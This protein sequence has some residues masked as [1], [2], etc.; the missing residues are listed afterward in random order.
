MRHLEIIATFNRLALLVLSLF[1]AS[2]AR[3]ATSTSFTNPI[4]IP[5][6]DDV[7]V[8]STAD[9]NNDGK[10]DLVYVDG[11]LSD[12]SRAIHVLLGN[13]NGTF[14]H[15]QDF[16]LPSGACCAMAIADVTNDGVLDLI[17]AGSNQFQVNVWV[18]IGNGDGSFQ[19]PLLTTFQPNNI[20]GY[21][22]L[23]YPI[24]VGD[25]NGDG[26]ADL[27]LTDISNGT[28]YAL[29]GNNSGQFTY[30]GSIQTYQTGPTYLV[31]L[32]GDGILDLIATDPLGA[33]FLVYLGKGDGTFPSFTRYS[34]G[35]AAGPFLLADVNQDG[36]PDILF[37]YYPNQLGYFP[38]NS[39][40]TFGAWVALGNAPSPNQLVSAADM[41][42]DGIPDLTFVTASGVA[43]ALGQTGPAYGPAQTTVTGGSTSPYSTL[44]VT[45]AVADFNGDGHPDFAMA[46]E[47]GIAIFLGNGNGTFASVEFYDM[48][49]EVGSAAVADFS[50]HGF[51]DIA[52]SLPAPLPRLLLGN[53]TGTFTLG[54][55]PNSSYASGGAAVT[56]LPADFNGDGKPDLNIGPAPIYESFSGTDSVAINA[57]NGSFETP[58]SVPNSTPIMADFNQDGRTDIIDVVGMQIVVS[59]GQANGTFETVNTVLRLPGGGFNVGD[60]NGDG[61]PD[62][63]LSYPDHF[64]VWLGNGDGTFTYSNSFVVPNLF[65]DFMAAVTDLDGD[66]KADIVFLPNPNVASPLGPLTILYGNGDG[67]FQ[68]PVFFATSHRFSWVT[69][70]DVNADGMPDLVLTD[71]A[72]IAVMLNLGNRTFGAETDYIAGRS[73]SVPVSVVDVNGDGLPDIVVGNSGG[74]TVTVLLNQANASSPSGAAVTGSLT[75]NPNPS[76]YLN[77]FTATVSLS[78]QSASSPVPT[79]TASFSVDGV[80]VAQ[81]PVNNGSSSLTEA[82]EALIPGQ[83]TVTAEYNGDANY[84][85]Q[86]FAAIQTIQPPVYATQTVLTVTP[87]SALA[88][89]TVRLTASVSGTPMPPGGV[90]TFYD[91]TNSIGSVSLNSQDI[92]YLDTSLLGAGT[93]ALTAEFQGFTQTAYSS[94]DTPYT[95]AIFSPSSSGSVTLTV[96]AY[97]TV[98]TLSSS[99]SSP[100]AGSVVTLTANV[101]SSE[102]TPFGG[103]SFYD[104]NSLL[105]TLALAADGA[106][107]FSTASLSTGSHTITA[108]F[109][110][111]GPF[112]TST[113]AA[114]AINVSFAPADMISTIV[115]LS[116]QID[117]ASGVST[118]SAEVSAAAGIPAGSVIFLDNGSILATAEINASGRASQQVGVLPSG[119]HSI[120]ASFA[121]DAKY[122]PGVSPA[123]YAQ[124]PQ[125]GPGFVLGLSAVGSRVTP[126]T[127]IT[128]E[129]DGT[130][131]FVQQVELT[132]TSDLP[133]GYLCNFSPATLAGHGTSILT[134]RSEQAN[135]PVLTKGTLLA[136][137][138]VGLVWLA[139]QDRRRRTSCAIAL[140]VTWCVLGPISGCN[141]APHVDAQTVVVTISAT[142]GSGADTIVQ[143]TEIQ[144]T[145]R[146]N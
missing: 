93:H 145:P 4:F 71:G 20:S 87:Q 41:N 70:A 108:T 19:Q 55:D 136:V 29:L 66:G 100:T 85:P 22:D 62:V 31:D 116:Q 32:N 53:G 99:N 77:S 45:P 88:S 120:T 112:A 51:Q 44:Q 126:S 33:D 113:S 6:S 21:P 11:N 64:E 36:H 30:N 81:N 102:G 144:F 125:T 35:T 40:G 86:I 105:G 134:I 9:L 28:I 89:Q 26:K 39:N 110:A 137:L 14:R 38:G 90:I 80:F 75:F 140:L 135:R 131:G 65:Y 79:G 59:L 46:A 73:V 142:S 143:S 17:V 106:V 7:L 57:G 122:S 43:V 42:G 132:C 8:L 16:N 5:T 91:G 95:A 104:G 63:L 123:L 98:T 47:G 94:S 68:S 82:A 56:L 18:L 48:G 25:I 78:G 13:G 138:V 118:L 60:V 83:H 101:S 67:T 69:V 37:D 121:G 115:S 107:G 24:A 119:A 124:W 141:T 129:I 72:A 3:A 74:T 15:A 109:N 139:S 58:F 114:V 84:A 97:T 111:N 54:S 96:T 76:N 133:Q 146:A 117:P 27:V 49:E 10:P 52:V 12:L 1:V 50:G 23:Q 103:V 127:P 128:V 130:P 2:Q 92:A 61:K 34:V